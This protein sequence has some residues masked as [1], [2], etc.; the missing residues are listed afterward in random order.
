MLFLPPSASVIPY[1]AAILPVFLAIPYLSPLQE[2]MDF[3]MD[4]M[5]F[6]YAISFIPLASVTPLCRRLS[7]HKPSWSC[8]WWSPRSLMHCGKVWIFGEGII[9]FYWHFRKI[10][11]P[12]VCRIL[13]RQTQ[14]EAG[15]PFRKLISRKE[16][17]GASCVQMC[18]KHNISKAYFTVFFPGF[19]IVVSAITS[20]QLDGLETSTTPVL[21][22]S[23]Y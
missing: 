21:V 15:K 10:S 7:S 18:R 8:Q 19:P 6:P 1:C 16:V 23:S 17:V 5:V 13:S 20:T 12:D 2:I 9:Q 14:V 11:L 22:Y 3:L 4:S